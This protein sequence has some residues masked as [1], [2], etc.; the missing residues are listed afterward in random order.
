MGGKCSA[1]K[2]PEPELPARAKPRSAPRGGTRP[3]R[4]PGRDR[5]TSAASHRSADSSAHA[6]GR[7]AADRPG[8]TEGVASGAA[9]AAAPPL[10]ERPEDPPGPPAAQPPAA[11]LL[12]DAP[13]GSCAECESARDRLLA[14][15]RR[16]ARAAAMLLARELLGRY[17]ARL[18]DKVRRRRWAAAGAAEAAGIRAELH[19]VDG[20]N[21]ALCRA[22]AR[23]RAAAADLLERRAAHDA[24]MRAYRRWRTLAALRPQRGAPAP[25][26]T[27]GRHSSDRR[28]CGSTCDE[29][30]ESAGIS[31]EHTHQPHPAVRSTSG[32][33]ESERRSPPGQPQAT[34]DVPARLSI[35]GSRPHNA[36]DGDYVLTGMQSNGMPMWE[37]VPYG[38]AS[39]Q[40]RLLFSTAEG[41]WMVAG[42]MDEV[43][44]GIGW[45][46]SVS[47]HGGLMPHQVEQW[48]NSADEGYDMSVMV[49]ALID[50]NNGRPRGDSEHTDGTPG[51]FCAPVRTDGGEDEQTA[52]P[53]PPTAG[54]TCSVVSS[55][56]MEGS[57]QRR[58]PRPSP[59]AEDC[60]RMSAAARLLALAR[61]SLLEVSAHEAARLADRAHRSAVAAQRVQSAEISPMSRPRGAPAVKRTFSS[62]P[63]QGPGSPSNR[64]VTSA[65]AV[66]S[67]GSC[68]PT[69]LRRPPSGSRLPQAAAC[70]AYVP[71]WG[72]PLICMNC[73][74]SKAAHQGD[75]EGDMS[76]SLRARTNSSRQLRTTSAC[77]SPPPGQGGSFGGKPGRRHEPSTV[78]LKWAEPL[79]PAAPAAK[80]VTKT[81]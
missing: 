33:E 22:V 3:Q 2:G 29:E 67:D 68:S 66:M 41:Y 50:A 65:G 11:P 24:R 37:R 75:A 13:A 21:E 60:E 49:T 63:G 34:G 19:R 51:L 81:F 46:C 5:A 58:K 30:T 42:S 20:E 39:E 31:S 9:P 23:G 69:A 62:A 70:F 48:E 38:A 35:T 28:L 40:E 56:G 12:E 26:A 55:T 43:H 16:T 57:M 47:Q 79:Q 72:K 44:K 77:A 7:P 80:G 10:P 71:T 61:E 6:P 15:Q 52:P 1:D 53:T 4:P 73:G 59:T 74:H 25:A 14:Q 32:G 17:F 27:P 54:L 76:C 8:L 18:G 64:S 45:L 78:P 36:C